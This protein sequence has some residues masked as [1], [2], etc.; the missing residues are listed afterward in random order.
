M[1]DIGN[2]KE[3][4]SYKEIKHKQNMDKKLLFIFFLSILPTDKVF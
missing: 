1:K 4:L 3:D 2:E